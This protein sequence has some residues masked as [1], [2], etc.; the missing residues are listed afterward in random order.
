MTHR[1]TKPFRIG[2][3]ISGEPQLYC[4][5]VAGPSRRRASSFSLDGLYRLVA[6]SLSM[7][8]ASLAWLVHYPQTIA[9]RLRLPEN[10][11]RPS[12]EIVP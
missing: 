9:S 8:S 4:K 1:T 12:E 11:D 2:D 10:F 5:Y 3:A 6:S 7:P